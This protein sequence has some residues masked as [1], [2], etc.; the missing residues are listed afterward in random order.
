MRRAN[1]AFLDLIQAVIAPTVIG[2]P[3]G[4][5]LSQA[6]ADASVLIAS[7][8]RHGVVRNFATTITG[9]LGTEAA[10]E[11]SASVDT[12]RKSR[13]IGVLLRDVSRRLSLAKPMDGLEASLSGLTDRIGKIPLPQLVR[14]T[15]GLI[16]RHYIEGALEQ[17]AGNRTAAAELLGLSRQ[18]L[19]AKLSRYGLDGNGAAGETTD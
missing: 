17:A 18:S 13:H 12:E 16:E 1:R 19:Y 14:D 4:R 11:I 3:L 15:G 6:G 9:E 8:L 2:E 10:V 5:W 7:V